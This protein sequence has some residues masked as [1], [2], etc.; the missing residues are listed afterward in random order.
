LTER[1]ADDTM[2]GSKWWDGT[3]SSLNLREIS[4]FGPTMTFKEGLAGATV[5]QTFKKENSPNLSIPD[6][7]ISGVSDTITFTE[8]A[9]I[10]TIKVNVDISHT[11]R[12]DLKVTLYAPTG[13]E[14]VLHDRKGGKDDD[15]K[16]TYDTVNLPGL[17]LLLGKAIKGEWPKRRQLAGGR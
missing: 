5:F 10:S 11:Y 16:T 2:P 8:T 4:K 3:S 12:G 7:N 1:F 6:N 15:I 17:S 9:T 13:E 14:I